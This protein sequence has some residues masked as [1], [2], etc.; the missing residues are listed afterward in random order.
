[1]D[2]LSEKGEPFNRVSEVT[3]ILYTV[4]RRKPNFIDNILR[5]NGLL[6]HYRRKDRRR[7]RSDVKTRKKK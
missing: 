7:D 2:A 3:N 4:K 6:R 1:L 5:G